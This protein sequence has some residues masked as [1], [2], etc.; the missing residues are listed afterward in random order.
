MKITNIDAAVEKIEN[1]LK[2]YGF[3]S[4]REAGWLEGVRS[5]TG[6]LRVVMDSEMMGAYKLTAN[7][8]LEW[9]LELSLQTPV[10]I[11]LA[12]ITAA[13]DEANL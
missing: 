13:L 7:S 11:L 9:K 10:A 1:L 3:K 6:F 2:D 5:K 12:T 4:G 8:C